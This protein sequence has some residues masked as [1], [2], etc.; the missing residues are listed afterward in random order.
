MQ[1]QYGSTGTL[2]STN[3][4]SWS[5]T[6]QRVRRAGWGGISVVKTT[7]NG[8]K[9]THPKARLPG[10]ESPCWLSRTLLAVALLA[11]VLL[12]DVLWRWAS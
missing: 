2:T 11:D 3:V 5:N 1:Y 8:D 4:E 7:T 9:G 6:F 12:A 10:S